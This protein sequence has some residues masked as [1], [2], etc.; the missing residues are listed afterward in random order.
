MSR[1]EE[2]GRILAS[3]VLDSPRSHGVWPPIIDEKVN[4]PKA[5]L[6]RLGEAFLIRLPVGPVAPAGSLPSEYRPL[7]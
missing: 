7:S 3:R 1:H 2:G 5:V 4:S 6:I